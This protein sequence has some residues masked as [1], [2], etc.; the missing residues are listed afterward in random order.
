MSEKIIALIP[1][2]GV[3]ARAQGEGHSGP[4]QYRDINGT[5]MLEHTV[6]A[7]LR[8]AGIAQVHIGVAPNDAY[9]DDC[10]MAKYDRVSIHRS[11]G[12]S[13][14]DTVLNTLLV[15][16][17][18]DDDW[19]LVHDAARPGLRFDCLG[20]L[21]KTC[22]QHDR[23]GILATPVPDTVKRATVNNGV[24]LIDATVPRDGL[25][26]AQ[27]P[28]MFRV[29]MLRDALM[30]AKEQGFEVTDEASAMEF[31]GYA[32]LLVKGSI[33]NMKVTWPEDFAVMEHWL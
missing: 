33:E 6:M 30:Q 2:G 18:G 20:R 32:P 13:R 16:G 29:G 17:G 19:V 27:T 9:I 26:L 1:A 11:G 14:A 8:H 31:T 28:Q 25:W 23:G 10:G 12:A 3:G 5:P 4:K 15:C 24:S 7:L 21:I 22:L